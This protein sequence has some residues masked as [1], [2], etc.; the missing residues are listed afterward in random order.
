MHPL[1]NT[2]IR[3][4]HK[5]G[6]YIARNVDRV[7][8]RKISRKGT[9]DFVTNIDQQAEQLIIETIR[10]LQPE[11]SFWGEEGG[12]VGESDFQWIIDPL[13]G[14][15]NFIHGNPQFAVSIALQIR[16]EL[17]VGVIYDPLRQEL[18][19][20]K[21]GEGAHLNDRR[22]RVSQ[23][24]ELAGSVIGTGIPFKDLEPLDD[25]LAMLKAVIKQQT[26]IRRAGSAALD[27]AWLAAGRLDGF[28]EL[29]LQPWDIAAGLLIVKEAGG[30]SS[31]LHGGDM[32]KTGNVVAGNPKIHPALLRTVSPYLPR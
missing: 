29:G 7:D 16:G 10:D 12:K 22:L 3:A 26:E 18:F 8:T 28:W 2:A 14:T 20:A 5:A 30:M 27:L 6:D 11:H 31:D 15:T 25:Y 9:N 21:R 13:D 17:E 4:A 23:R 1:V 24:H 19:T 32:L